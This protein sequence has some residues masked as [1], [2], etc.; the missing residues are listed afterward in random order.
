MAATSV[1]QSKR[2]P[3]RIVQRA[4]RIRLVLAPIAGNPFQATIQGTLPLPPALGTKMRLAEHQ[5]GN[6]AT[7]R[8]V[9]SGLQDVLSVGPTRT[10]ARRRCMSSQVLGT[11]SLY[12]RRSCLNSF[13]L[14]FSLSGGLL[15]GGVPT[16]RLLET[17]CV[18]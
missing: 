3:A 8:R 18:W 6:Q 1:A 2:Q 15:V 4:S 16:Y 12:R 10:P 14:G 11:T 17:A 7:R 13:C 5:A 9:S